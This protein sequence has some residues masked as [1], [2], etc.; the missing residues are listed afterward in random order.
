MRNKTGISVFILLVLGLHAIPVL[1]YQGDRQ[2][3]WPF[4][5]W[6]MYESPFPRPDGRHNRKL[7]ATS[8]GGNI[9]K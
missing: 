6:A 5:A 9:R 1:F 7:F 3:R 8:A 2:T 4:L